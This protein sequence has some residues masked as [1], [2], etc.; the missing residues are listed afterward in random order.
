MSARCTAA[1]AALLI[2]GTAHA[3]TIGA[4]I[5][6]QHYPQRD[7]NNVNPGLYLRTDAG[8]TFG[9]YRNSERVQ[10]FY[11]GWTCERNAGPVSFAATAGLIT[12]Y[13]RATVLPMLVPS[14]ALPAVDGWRARISFV[15]RFEK[16]GSNVVHLSVERSL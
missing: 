16:S 2:C 3:A 12:G 7:W 13:R 6:S 10:S 4:H 5:A 1:L 14:V 9:T 15:P 11:A 8:L